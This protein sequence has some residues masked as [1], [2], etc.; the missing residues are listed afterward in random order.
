LALNDWV[1]LDTETMGLYDAHIVEIAIVNPLGEP[2][3]NTFI[4]PTIPIPSEA[5]E[6]HGI[7]DEMVADVPTSPGI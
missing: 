6:I 1:F 4:K 5:R 3:L 2:L 7:T